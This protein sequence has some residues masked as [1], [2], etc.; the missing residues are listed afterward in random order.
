M[1]NNA[2]LH[3]FLASFELWLYWLIIQLIWLPNSFPNECDIPPWLPNDLKDTEDPFLF[4]LIS[5]QT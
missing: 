5:A 2:L 3:D 4:C 1:T